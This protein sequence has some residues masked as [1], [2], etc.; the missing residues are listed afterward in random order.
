ML[1]KKNVCFASDLLSADFRPS[2]FTAKRRRRPETAY[3]APIRPN[4]A[5]HCIRSSAPHVT[6]KRWMAWAVSAAQRK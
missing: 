5:R 3:T 1:A 2:L 4:A 6:V